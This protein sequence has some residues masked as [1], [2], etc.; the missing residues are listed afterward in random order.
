[1]RYGHSQG[2]TLTMSI[3]LIKGRGLTGINLNDIAIKCW[4]LSLHSRSKLIHDLT[5]MSDNLLDNPTHHN[6]ESKAR[7]HSDSSDRQK[8]QAKL[9]QCIEPLSPVR[10]S[11]TLFNIVSGKL[12]DSSVNVHNALQL[13]KEFL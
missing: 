10:H 4:S 9:S 7:M 3:Y 2:G 1:M 5:L 13:G 12:D 11:T 6:E 8:I